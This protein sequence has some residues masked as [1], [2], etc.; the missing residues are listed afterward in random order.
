MRKSHILLILS[1][2]L[3]IPFVLYFFLTNYTQIIDKNNQPEHENTFYNFNTQFFNNLSGSSYKLKLESLFQS[4]TIVFNN[5]LDDL[6][7]PY[8]PNEILFD[9]TNEN[10]TKNKTTENE[11]EQYT[12]INKENERLRKIHKHPILILPGFASSY[13]EILYSP[14]TQERML[15]GNVNFT[16]MLLMNKVNAIRHLLVNRGEIKHRKNCKCFC[17]ESNDKNLNEKNLDTKHVD[18]NNFQSK[19]E[20]DEKSRE[21]FCSETN[22]F[23]DTL[24]KVR[25]LLSSANI[26]SILD[27]NLIWS[28]II[29]KLFN[30]GYDDL[31]LSIYP[32]DWRL[33]LSELEC[34]DKLFTRMRDT[35]QALAK[36][37][38]KKVVLLCHS[39]GGLVAQKLIDPPEEIIEHIDGTKPSLEN[40]EPLESTDD[41]EKHS[42]MI[43][44]QKNIFDEVKQFLPQWLFDKI[45]NKLNKSQP[46]K[47]KG[48]KPRSNQEKR[49]KQLKKHNQW[50]KRN[51]HTIITIGTPYLG[52]PS[53]LSS[54]LFGIWPRT[55]LLDMLFDRNSIIRLFNDWNSINMLLGRNMDWAMCQKMKKFRKVHRS[56][57]TI[58]NKN[59]KLNKTENQNK[60]LPIIEFSTGEKIY[61]SDIPY[62][63]KRI[64]S[65]RIFETSDNMK[66]QKY[67]ERREC[68]EPKT[69]FI[70]NP[71]ITIYTFY[72]IGVRTPAAFFFDVEPCDHSNHFSTDNDSEIRKFFPC[73]SPLNILPNPYLSAELSRTDNIYTKGIHYVDGD[74][75]VPLASL[76]Y[77]SIRY[78]LQ[79]KKQA[80]F[81]EKSDHKGDSSEKKRNSDKPRYVIREY[82]HIPLPFYTAPRGGSNNAQHTAI[83]SNNELLNDIIEIVTGKVLDERVLSGV[84]DLLDEENQDQYQDILEEIE[85]I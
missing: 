64:K 51:I 55:N 29:L 73:C 24:I 82:E 33:C 59:Y 78:H 17:E 8:I 26:S 13:L 52:A 25:A 46:Q 35:I 70:N 36:Y 66:E 77:K 7:S 47:K 67:F 85:A 3:L 62:L 37:N 58:N 79:E 60:I 53:L 76:A 43:R 38:K 80:K 72:G 48:G 39:M 49:N 21:N 50:V 9:M 65:G 4:M 41:L 30:I 5:M 6:L 84:K 34:R 28:K 75:T 42:Y 63:F 23:E 22:T 19:M 44:I 15:F 74:G 69:K 12:E 56:G 61:F 18:K 1:L 27:V 81:L 2:C 45:G 10:F 54:L 16:K 11:S 83:L 68:V 14:Y 57:K 32:Y 31:S 20:F 71:P 40:N